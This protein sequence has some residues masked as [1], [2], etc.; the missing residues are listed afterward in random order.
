MTARTFPGTAR[1]LE[2]Q[3]VLPAPLE[4]AELARQARALGK[5]LRK[6]KRVLFASRRHLAG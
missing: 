5:A 2:S 3:P 1:K 4:Q 6:G